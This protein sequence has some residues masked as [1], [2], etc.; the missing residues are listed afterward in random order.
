MAGLMER[1]AAGEK[2][3]ADGATGTQ[4]QARGLPDGHCPELWNV[5]RPD[6]VGA[7]TADYVAAGSDL[8]YTNSF[9]GSIWRLQ[10][11]GLQDRAA[12]LNTAAAKVA[13]DAAGDQAL[14]VGSMGPSGQFL[15]PLGLLTADEVTAAYGQ[16]AA[17]LAAGGADALV[18]ETF[19]GLDEL[20]AALSGVMAACDL[21]VICSL[22]YGPAVRTMAGVAPDTAAKVLTAAGA[23][24]MGLNCG[25]DIEVVPKVL[26]AYLEAAPDTPCLMKPNAGLP[27]TTGGELTWPMDPE[28]FAAL[29]K[30][31]LAAGAALVGGCCGTTPAH[32]A[33]LRRV[34]DEG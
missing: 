15:E 16:Q 1:L 3:L 14:V 32:I 22:T 31:W 12:E 21:P 25:D 4:L 30:T 8:V 28:E 6:A 19:Y 7:V 24:I 23:D 5:E 13:K 29:A 10:M 11:H 27:I 17:A 33:A 34:V 26:A 20:E 2:L 18:L 9:G